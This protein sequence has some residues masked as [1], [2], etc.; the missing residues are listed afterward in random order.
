V[1]SENCQLSVNQLQ[2]VAISRMGI[3]NYDNM[4][5]QDVLLEDEISG[6]CKIYGI[7]DGHG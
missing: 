5:N 7:F 2:A 1:G 4:E 3:R 6:K